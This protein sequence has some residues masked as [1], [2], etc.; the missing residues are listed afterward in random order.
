MLW[1][2]RVFVCLCTRW[3]ICE[4][5]LGGPDMTVVYN[6]GQTLNKS[7]LKAGKRDGDGRWMVKR[8]KVKIM[9]P[10]KGANIRL[11]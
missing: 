5:Y 8:R 10:I 11:Q 9:L 7:G 6:V 3:H 4:G 2:V 1:G